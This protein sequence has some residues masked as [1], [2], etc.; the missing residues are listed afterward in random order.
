MGPLSAVMIGAPLAPCPQI[1][2]DPIVKNR[3]LRHWFL[4]FQVVTPLS[5]VPRDTPDAESLTCHNLK[6]LA[7]FCLHSP[8]SIQSIPKAGV[9]P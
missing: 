1:L 6:S 5:H 9:Q 7:G 4:L 2:P 8:R 3:A